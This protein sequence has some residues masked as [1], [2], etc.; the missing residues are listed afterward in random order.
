MAKKIK[1]ILEYDG[2]RY[3]GF[4]KQINANTIQAELEAGIK[5][6]TGSEISIIGA[7]RT[8][9]GVHAL[10]QVIA[11]TAESSIPPEKWAL[12]LNSV[13]PGD[14]RII[15]SSEAALNFHPQ[16]DALR[17]QYRYLIYRG[18]RG[19]SFFRNYA[20]VNREDLDIGAM[21]EACTI[22]EGHHNFKAFC[23]SG[24]SVK[25]FERT[26]YKCQLH[27]KEDMLFLDIEADGFLYNMVRII[28]GSL[29]EIGRARM[30]AGELE[31]AFELGER[32]LLG[33]TAAPQG[34]YLLRVD[35][36]PRDKIGIKP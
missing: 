19:S 14:I 32:K 34:L 17:K 8:D 16:F 13:L 12:A 20:L 22:I 7:G 18:V 5:E 28:T 30:K 27:E 31:K 35:Y 26:V 2:S 3:H 25:S 33:P 24:S 4:Q 6:L 10:G 1:M 29:L 23:A 11:F 36:P 21:Q 9:A 15:E